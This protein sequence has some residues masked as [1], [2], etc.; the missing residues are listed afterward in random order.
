MIVALWIVLVPM[1]IGSNKVSVADN[2]YTAENTSYHI[3]SETNK[4]NETIDFL[5]SHNISAIQ[6]STVNTA[7]IGFSLDKTKN[8][9]HF[10]YKNGRTISKNKLADNKRHHV[11]KLF[12]IYAHAVDYFI[13]MLEHII[14]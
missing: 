6:L 2:M 12:S 7:T 5:L 11:E 9:S 13:Y 14:I 3:Q 10:K 1:L 4:Q 8:L